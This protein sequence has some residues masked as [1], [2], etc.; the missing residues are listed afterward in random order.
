MTWTPSR[1]LTAPVDRP[2]RAWVKTLGPQAAKGYDFGGCSNWYG[3]SHACT[4]EAIEDTTCTRC[5]EYIRDGQ[6]IAG[7]YGADVWADGDRCDWYEIWHERC[8]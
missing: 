7:K 2:L 8:P 6:V 3:P 4:C 5:G 1:D